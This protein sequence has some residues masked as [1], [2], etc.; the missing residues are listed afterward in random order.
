MIVESGVD[1]VKAGRAVPVVFDNGFRCI[2]R[3]IETE[4]FDPFDMTAF[5]MIGSGHGRPVAVADADASFIVSRVGD[6]HGPFEILR[7]LG[8]MGEIVLVDGRAFEPLADLQ[9]D[10]HD[11]A[12]RDITVA[13]KHDLVV[14]LPIMPLIQAECQ[15]HL[16][17]VAKCEQTL[18]L[19]ATP[20][21]G[22]PVELRSYFRIAAVGTGTRDIKARDFASL[23]GPG[24]RRVIPNATG[25]GLGFV[26]AR[27]GG[28]AGAIRA[29]G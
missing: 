19:P 7:H 28:V 22:V 27:R 25:K 20:A 1:G 3:G 9:H 23:V 11:P 26:E 16:G 24:C 12:R 15:V 5:L 4:T 29:G 8:G 2:G 6:I 18:E 21:G 14:F 10:G 17:G 13:T